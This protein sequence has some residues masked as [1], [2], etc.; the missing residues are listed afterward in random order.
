MTA[1]RADQYTDPPAQVI[2]L[3]APDLA[4]IDWGPAV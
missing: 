4:A 2:V 3:V 1:R